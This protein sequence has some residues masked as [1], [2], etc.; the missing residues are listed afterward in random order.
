MLKMDQNITEDELNV[1][2]NMVDKDKNDNI[3]YQGS[4][5]FFTLILLCKFFFFRIFISC[6]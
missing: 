6:A 3:D 5:F 4:F 2:F 1:M